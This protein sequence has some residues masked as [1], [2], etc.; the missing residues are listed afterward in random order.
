MQAE[1]SKLKAKKEIYSLF[2]LSALSLALRIWI[3]MP[4]EM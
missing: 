1:S 2:I 3:G 4:M